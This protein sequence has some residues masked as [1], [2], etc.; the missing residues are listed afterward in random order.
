MRIGWG[1]STWPPRQLFSLLVSR[2]VDEAM[3]SHSAHRRRLAHAVALA[4]GLCVLLCATAV[5]GDEACSAEEGPI[6]CEACRE[7]ADINAASGLPRVNYGGATVSSNLGEYNWVFCNSTGHCDTWDGKGI[8][9][10]GAAADSPASY[11]QSLGV[12][13]GFAVVMAIISPLF[14]LCCCLLRCCTC[15]GGWTPTYVVKKNGSRR[16]FGCGFHRMRNPLLK[17]EDKFVYPTTQTLLTRVLAIVACILVFTFIGV[18]QQLGNVAFTDS[19]QRLAMAPS[20]TVT[21]IRKLITP[22]HSLIVDLAGNTLVPTVQD[23]N[24]TLNDAVDLLVLINATECIVDKAHVPTEFDRL[25]EMVLDVLG[26]RETITDMNP[27]VEGVFYDVR[28]AT[29]AIRVN[30]PKLRKLLTDLGTSKTNITSQLTALEAQ[31][32]LFDH[33]I[34]TFQ[35]PSTGVGSVVS[36]LDDASTS[37]NYPTSTEIDTAADGGAN[38]PSLQELLSGSSSMVG[39]ESSTPRDQ[40]VTSLG[41]MATKFGALPNTTRTATNLENLEQLRAVTVT[42]RTVPVTDAMLANL[43]AAGALVPG[44]STAKPPVDDIL[45]CLDRLNTTQFKT[46]S[47]FLNATV[48]RIP[49]VPEFVSVVD[50]VRLFV[51]AKLG[52]V[53]VR[54]IQ[55]VVVCVCACVCVCAHVDGAF[56]PWWYWVCVYTHEHT[57]GVPPGRCAAVH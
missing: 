41:Q 39:V 29:E 33:S 53:A 25:V 35:K 9:E 56:L 51:F 10:R 16:C 24:A 13:V 57:P 46:L 47:D 15:C 50:A 37:S 49:N 40:L 1:G 23:V 14:F 36:D 6:T 32:A 42:N 5:R 30:T 3:A 44:L 55:N 19:M 2:K 31:I 52:V 54:C 28:N 26:L 48:N 38:T 12:Y 17:P 4:A 43:E 18:G 11:F 22:G 20:A 34:D 27:E 8:E 7:G 21:T 45:A